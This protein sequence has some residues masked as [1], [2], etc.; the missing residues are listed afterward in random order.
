MN[1]ASSAGCLALL[2]IGLTAT[3]AFAGGIL[4]IASPAFGTAC[5]IHGTSQASAATTHGTGTASGNLAGLPMDSPVNHCGGADAI[6]VPEVQFAGNAVGIVGN[7]IPY[8]R[9]PR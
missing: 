3:P 4:P 1:R 8:F 6:P 7:V 2:A 9:S 5:T